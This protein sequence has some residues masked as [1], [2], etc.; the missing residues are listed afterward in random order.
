MSN[1]IWESTMFAPPYSGRKE[2]AASFLLR[3][4]KGITKSAAD[5]I[6]S[7]DPQIGSSQLVQGTAVKQPLWVATSGTARD[8]VRLDGSNDMLATAAANTDVRSSATGLTVMFVVKGNSTNTGDYPVLAAT[9]P[10][11]AQLDN[12]WAIS[13]NGSGMSG[14]LTTHFAQS[15]AGWDHTSTNMGA[16]AGISK[17]KK[18]VWAVVFDITAKRLRYYINGT[19]NVERSPTFPSSVPA[20]TSVFTIGGSSAGTRY[21]GADLY[22][23]ATFQSPLSAATIAAISANWMSVYGVES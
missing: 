19:L 4:D 14:V 11:T 6:S 21:L 9:R 17:T 16:T 23:L 18:Q 2:A 13:A 5:A 12:G 3:A 22:N 7:W 10:W 1:R 8:A 20:S 15:S